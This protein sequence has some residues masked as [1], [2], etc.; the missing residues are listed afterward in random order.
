MTIK[1]LLGCALLAGA[2]AGACM[3]LVQQQYIAPLLRAAEQ[4]KSAPQGAHHHGAAHQSQGRLSPGGQLLLNIAV[5]VGWALILVAIM[6][7]HGAVYG[8]GRGLLWGAAAFL[9]CF[10]LPALG[11]TPSLPGVESALLGAR[12]SWWLLQVLTGGLGLYLLVFGRGAT[13]FAGAALGAFPLL[14]GAPT[15]PA[16]ALLSL[17]REQ[18]AL[19]L[20]FLYGLWGANLLFWLVLGSLIGLLGAWGWRTR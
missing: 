17:P 20:D 7:L 10:A 12:Q 19:R 18:A 1:R 4:W 3:H 16:G 11:M 6:E 14:L 13:R 15:P 9:V 2:L 5:G 8:A